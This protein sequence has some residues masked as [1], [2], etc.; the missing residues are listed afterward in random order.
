[1]YREN[2]LLSG[3]SFKM[4]ERERL[5]PISVLQLI[6]TLY[7]SGRVQLPTRQTRQQQQTHLLTSAAERVFCTDPHPSIVS[8]GGFTVM[9]S[10]M[11]M[12]SQDGLDTSPDQ[13]EEPMVRR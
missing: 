4:A 11:V 9:R 7:L 3:I 1:M 12:R 13:V 8:S 5:Q 2:G 10:F 6:C